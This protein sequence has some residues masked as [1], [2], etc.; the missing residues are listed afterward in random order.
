MSAPPRP[1]TSPTAALLRGLTTSASALLLTA[2]LAAG[3]LTSGSP[4]RTAG[5]PSGPSPTVTA[6]ALHLVAAT[7]RERVDYALR[8]ARRHR[9]D[10]Y[11]YGAAGP[12]RFDCSGLV[13]FAT[14]RAG[15]RGVPRTSAAQGRF[16]RHIKKKKLRRGDFIFFTG[17]SGVYHVGIYVGRRGGDPAV[18]HAPMPGTKV[19]VEKIWTHSWF[20]GTLRG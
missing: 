17:S 1:P 20:A 9:G 12:R 4:D 8:T 15:F 18:L 19:R 6:G 14:H 3:Q 5:S 10:P 2:A 13:Y 11:K 16:M 7:V